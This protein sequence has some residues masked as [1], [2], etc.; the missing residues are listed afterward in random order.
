[1]TA[2]GAGVLV[3]VAAAAA[4][5]VVRRPARSLA[6]V[7]SSVA[8]AHQITQGGSRQCARTTLTP[9]HANQ[10]YV[11]NPVVAFGVGNRNHTT[12]PG[13]F[14]PG[15]RVRRTPNTGG[16]AVG[17]HGM[18]KHCVSP[19]TTLCEQATRAEMRVLD[20]QPASPSMSVREGSVRG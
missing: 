3:V 20:P 10:A 18:Q 8:A 7:V 11:I 12:R 19:A 6:G 4:P 2:A 5:R 9:P 17:L 14:R 13:M 1:M 16:R 15:H